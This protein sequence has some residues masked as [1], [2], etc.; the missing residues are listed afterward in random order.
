MKDIVILA[1]FTGD[2]NCES[3]NRFN[4]L[5]EELAKKHHVELV[6]TDF[7]HKLKDRRDISSVNKP[8]KT[9]FIHEPKYKR[10][11][12]IRRFYSHF[13]WGNRVAAYLRKRE[14]PD[15]VYCAVPSLTGPQKVAQYCHK[16]GIRFIIDIQDLWPEAFG[17]VVKIPVLSSILFSPFRYHANK[18]YSKADDI[19]AVSEEYVQRALSVNKKN[20]KGYAVYIGT[21]LEKYDEGRKSEPYARKPK[22]EL[23]IGYCGSLAA[24]YDIPNLIKAV[25]IL[26]QRGFANIRLII[27]GDG[28]HKQTFVDIATEKGIP[29]LFTGRL[30]YTRMCAQIDQCD[31]VVNPIRSGSAASIINKHGDYAASGKPVVNSQE[32]RE[33]RDLIERYHMGLNCNC[34][35]ALDMAQKLEILITDSDLRKMMGENARKCAEE[36]FDRKFTYQTIYDLMKE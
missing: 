35:D 12:S 2:L 14:K 33:Y 7:S 5:C 13:V 29:V 24:S 26:V 1:H 25:E 4:Y 27:M 36:K 23:W 21:K 6:T 15:I 10:N 22:G 17:M 20:A 18:I 34:E 32:N 9:T 31:I 19:V 16:N 8:F 3:N 30:L 28:G 11:V